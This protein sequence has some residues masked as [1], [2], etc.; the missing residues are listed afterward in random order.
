MKHLTLTPDPSPK[1]REERKKVSE[2]VAALKRHVKTYS[3]VHEIESFHRNM[4]KREKRM[5]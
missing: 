4:N 1:G 2:Y 3:W 5:S